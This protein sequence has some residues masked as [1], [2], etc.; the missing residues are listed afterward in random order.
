MPFRGQLNHDLYVYTNVCKMLFG[1]V[2][3][4]LS[5]YFRLRASSTTRGHDYKL[6]QTYSR[7]N[8]RKHFFAKE[9]LINGTILNV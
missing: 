3:L 4:K 7:F 9:L 8:V 2:G 5:D 6:F 1:L